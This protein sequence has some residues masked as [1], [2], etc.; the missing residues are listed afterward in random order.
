MDKN[1]FMNMFLKK[2]SCLSSIIQGKSS[3]EERDHGSYN[4]HL[5]EKRS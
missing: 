2:K 4:N 3:N 1:E 5:Y